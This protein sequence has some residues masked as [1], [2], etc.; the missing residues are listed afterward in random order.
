M[1][2]SVVLG[3]DVGVDGDDFEQ[4]GWSLRPLI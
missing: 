1:V 3:L 4:K 2:G